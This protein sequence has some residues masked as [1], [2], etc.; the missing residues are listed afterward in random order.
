MPATDMEAGKNEIIQKF[1]RWY[2]NKDVVPTSEALQKLTAF[3]HD[4]DIDILKLGCTLQNLA[5]FC[6]HK[7]TDAKFY[8]ITEGD[9]DLLEKIRKDFVG[10]P[11]I[12]FTRK[13]I[14]EENFLRKSTKICKSIFG[15]DASQLYSYSMCQLCLSVFTGVEI[16]FQKLVDSHLDKRTPAALKNWSCPISNEQDQNVKLNASLQQADRKKSTASMLMG[17]VLIA[18]LCLKPWVAFTT[19]VPVKSCVALS[20]KRIFNVVARRESSMHWDD[21]IYKREVTRLMK[22]GSAMV[23]TKQPILLNNIS[24]NTFLTGVH[25]QLSFFLKE[26]KEGKLFGYAQCNI[27]VLGKLRANFANFLPIFNNTLVSNS[28]MGDLM[29]N[30]A[31]EEKL[32]SQPQ[33]M[34][35]SSLKLQNETLIY[36]PLQFYLQLG[37]VCAPFVQS[38]VDARRQGDENLNSSVIAETMK[39]LANS[40]Y[41]YQIMDS[42]RHIITTFLTDGNT[43]SAII[44]KLFKKL[45]L[46]NNLLYEVE[47]AKAQIEHKEPVIVGFFILQHAKLRML[48]LYYNFFTRFCDVNTF[49][50]LEVDT[51]SLNLAL[52][53]KELE[54]YI[55]SK[56]RAQWQRLRSNDCVDNLTADA[57]ANFFPEHVVKKTNNMIGERLASSKKNSDIRKC[58]VCVVRHT[59]AMTSPLMNLNLAVKVTTKAYWN[60]AAT[61]HW[62]TIEES[63]TKK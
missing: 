45:D 46:V 31:E 24:E 27:E 23:E 33:K 34:L 10:G 3:Y 43:H 4:K 14:V 37:L 59:V 28:D 22:C 6:I 1:L 9:K 55:W 51:D 20:L 36:P 49:E 39:L 2:N 57:V 11:S 58:C 47:L 17:F 12:V 8:P 61:N 53:K 29:K 25:L 5:K 44:S 52:A 16:S 26:M 56:M 19:S 13:A 38:A 7:A 42:S 35:I 18:T 40:C 15:V 54:D 50:E 41:G 32:L 63:W 30:Y 21:L 60:R 62:K 48:E